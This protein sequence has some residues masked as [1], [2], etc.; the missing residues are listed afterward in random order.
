MERY[1]GLLVTSN[2]PV[3]ILNMVVATVWL[4]DFNSGMV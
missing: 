1:N 4:Q 3:V 2:I